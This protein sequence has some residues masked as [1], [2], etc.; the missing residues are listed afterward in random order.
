[1]IGTSSNVLTIVLLQIGTIKKKKKNLAQLYDALRGDALDAVKTS[2]ISCKDADEIMQTLEIRFGN[3]M[4]IG[5]SI[6]KE[7]KRLP[8]LKSDSGKLITD[9]N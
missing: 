8:N 7:L 6:L 9:R 1:M 3:P 2:F 4:L 5:D